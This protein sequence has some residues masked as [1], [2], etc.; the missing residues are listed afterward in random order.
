MF[1]RW[2]KVYQPEPNAGDSTMG[3]RAHIVTK[4][5]CEYGGTQAFNYRAEEV[6]DM[7]TDNGVHVWTSGGE[8]DSYGH[9]EVN[10][11]SGALEKYIATLKKLPPDEINSYFKHDDQDYTNGYVCEILEEWLR[12]RDPTGAVIRIHWG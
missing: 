9:W 5:V 11:A 6:Y 1:R 3:I 8:G 4:Y 12:L 7:L 2:D 10:Y